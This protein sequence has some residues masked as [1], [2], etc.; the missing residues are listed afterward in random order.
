MEVA[1]I[2]NYEVILVDDG[3]EVISRYIG[4][5]MLD[6]KP[7]FRVECDEYEPGWEYMF[8]YSKNNYENIK[9]VIVDAIYECDDMDEVL[10]VLSDIFESEFCDILMDCDGDCESCEFCDYDEYED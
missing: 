5:T 7:M 9:H 2:R 3:E 10:D 4:M 6:D 1:G 8:A